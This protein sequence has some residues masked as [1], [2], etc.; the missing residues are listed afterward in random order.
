M[1]D[2]R[3]ATL[4]GPDTVLGEADVEDFRSS[5]RGEMICPG[6]AGYDEAR[7]VWNG[8]IDR[9]PGLIVRCAGVSDVIN[10]VNFART[11]DL[12][13]AVRGG[14]HNVRGNA[15]CDGGI[16]ID[17]SQM[18]GIRVD[19]RRRT[20]RAQAGLTWL[21]YDIET[22]AFGLASPGG[23]VSDTG[24]AGLTLGGGI[25]WLSGKHGLA[26]DNLLSV[27]MVTADGRFLTASPTE[28]ADL[29]WGVRGGGGN[30]GVVT[31]FEYQLHPVGPVLAGLLVHPFEKA[32]EV[33]EIYR[34]LSSTFPDEINTLAGFLSLPDGTPAVG[35]LVCYNGPLESGE[36]AL[37]P[38]REFGSP[39]SDEIRPMAYTELQTLL[40]EAV[41][42]GRQY[43]FKSSFTRDINDEIIEA[44]VDY[45]SKATSPLSIVMFQQMGGATGRVGEGETAFSHRDARY[46]FVIAAAWEDPGES[47]VHIRWARDLWEAIERFTTGGSY[48]N[49]LGLEAEEGSDQI[50]AGYGGN[51]ERLIALKNKYDPTNLFRHNPNI[52]PTG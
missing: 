4:T 26:C 13:V 9:R 11:N 20:A 5:L 3:V 23:T 33:L 27:D 30:F 6:D 46:D 15:V 52:K 14:G 17:M 19:P 31:S 41:P 48:I 39:L 37:R 29:F 38:L 36:K 8:M 10:S 47:E 49:H 21:D 12:L 25:G 32:K 24:I 35:I 45:Y 40:D 44:L 7:K 1:V 22:Q 16:V 18:K 34:D 2:L 28:N 42:S 51:Y 50:K 43:Y